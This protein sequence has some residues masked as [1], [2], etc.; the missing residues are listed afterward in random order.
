MK[1]K[2]IYS[3]C[4]EIDCDGFKVLT[5]PWF[6]EGIYDG[7][8]Y[9]FPKI[10]P[11][12]YITKPDL[13]YISHIH[14]D[15]YDPVFL[16]KLIQK[17][18]EI[19]ILIPDL[20]HNFLQRKGKFDGLDLEPSRHFKNSKIELYI[21]E[22]DTGSLSDIDSAMILKDLTSNQVL[23]NLNDCIFTQKHIDKLK[24]IIDSI[25][26]KL[27]F[28]AVGYTGA[29]PFPQTYF[30]AE[31]DIERLKEEANNKKLKFFDRY[32]QF[33]ET[34]KA[35][36]NLPFAG[37]YILG[38]KL[39]HLNDYRGTADAFEIAAI[40]SKALILENGGSIDL[41]TNEI[42]N[43][44]ESLYDQKSLL[45]RYDEVSK[46]LLDYEEDI[47]LDFQKINFQRLIS[48][49]ASRA[50][51]KSEIQGN[52]DFIF[53]LLDKDESVIQRFHLRTLDSVTNEIDLNQT[54]ESTEFS[55]IMIDY[56][57]F[58]GLLTSVYHWNNAEVGSQFRTIRVPID[59]FRTEVR[60]YLNFFT[61]A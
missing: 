40:D 24:Q 46:H 56:R 49:A 11:F 23:L 4:L 13:I 39:V 44:R 32:K 25:T 53:S 60:D 36:I 6:T 26:K 1:I 31:K 14:P 29:G 34:F 7:S 10:D 37:E 18:G 38:G 5:D 50:Q 12:K 9:Q 22:N 3:A 15:H 61:T 8:W 20:K 33:I 51:S 54:I 42:T 57:Y 2:Y 16:R 30:D 28:L 45:R 27:N 59:N 41:N 55:E 52:Y 58:Y 19:P 48:S 43:V 21:E 35:D 47:D 17:Y